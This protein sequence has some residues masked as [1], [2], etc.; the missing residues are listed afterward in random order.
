MRT[1]AFLKFTTAA[2]VAACATLIT[3]SASAEVNW[4]VNV[5]IPGVVVSEPAPVYVEPAPVYAPPPPVYYRPASRVYYG[6]PPPVYYRPAPVYG[7]P[8]YYAPDDYRPKRRH[9]HHHHRDRDNDDQ[10]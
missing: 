5:G 2:A 7:E 4:S 1:T 8:I 10:D 6:A 3:N 9:H